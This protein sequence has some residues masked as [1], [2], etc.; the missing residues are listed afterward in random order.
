MFSACVYNK[1][2]KRIFTHLEKT[3]T[4]FNNLLSE[5]IL[6]VCSPFCPDFGLKNFSKPVKQQRMLM[7]TNMEHSWGLLVTPKAQQI[8]Y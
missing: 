3:N 5:V 8:T 6:M 4:A 7:L 1:Q 2:K